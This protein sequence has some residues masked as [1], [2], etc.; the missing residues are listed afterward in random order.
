MRRVIFLNSHY[1]SLFDDMK[2]SLDIA[3]PEDIIE[4]LSRS[5]VDEIYHF[6]SKMCE[7]G[8]PLYKLGF[9]TNA[10]SADY[11]HRSITEETQEEW[12]AAMRDYRTAPLDAYCP[13][14]KTIVLWAVDESARGSTEARYAQAY[15]NGMLGYSFVNIL[16]AMTRV[17]SQRKMLGSKQYELAV[18]HTNLVNVN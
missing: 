16:T 8:R 6:S 18:L 15:T 4:Y 10:L 12:D 17:M 2:W 14:D 11:Q 5:D 3:R 1:K 7:V 13:D 9:T